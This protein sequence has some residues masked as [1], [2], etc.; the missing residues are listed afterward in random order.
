YFGI[1]LVVMMILRPQG[2]F[3]VR[4]KLLSYGR[5]VYQAV[6]RPTVG[7]PIGAGK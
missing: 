3:P 7:E 6:R 1:A 4:Q 5:Q 2:L